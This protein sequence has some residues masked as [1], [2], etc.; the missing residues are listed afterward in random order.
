VGKR[1]RVTLRRLV[2]SIILIVFIPVVGYGLLYILNVAFYSLNIGVKV[3]LIDIPTVVT[4]LVIEVVIR[5]L[6]LFLGRKEPCP[7]LKI[8]DIITRD[9]D[10]GDVRYSVYVR[11][12]GEIG[13]ESCVAKITLE[14]DTLNAIGGGVNSTD[15]ALR[16]N[17]IEDASIMWFPFGK[18][19][20]DIRP[21]EQGRNRLDV[22]RVAK[23]ADGKPSMFIFPS[24]KGWSPALIALKPAAY[25]GVIKIS[26]MNAKPCR[27]KFLINYDEKT[28]EVAVTF[29]FLLV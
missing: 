6:S 12:L 23:N 25:E 16:Y 19:A 1:T 24:A 21:D 18:E 10:D 8:L 20:I 28:G 5:L 22:F 7:D 11:N 9:D 15:S 3:G 13:A 17:R 26:P 2:S 14:Y 4:F 27:R 29:P